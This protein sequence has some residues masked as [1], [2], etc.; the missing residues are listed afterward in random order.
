MNNKVFTSMVAGGIVMLIAFLVTFFG[1]FKSSFGENGML[2]VVGISLLC[3][4]VGFLG[5]YLRLTFDEKR[6]NKKHQKS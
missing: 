5:S 3:G 6:K 1:D 2:A 4:G